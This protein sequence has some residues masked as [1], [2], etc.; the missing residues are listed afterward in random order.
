[1]SSSPI[2]A[3]RKKLKEESERQGYGV[4]RLDAALD[5]GRTIQSGVQP[6]H[7]KTPPGASLRA[8]LSCR[9]NIRMTIRQRFVIHRPVRAGR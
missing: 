2:T 5:S 3:A 6:P 1:M 8:L 7:S 4:R 9:S